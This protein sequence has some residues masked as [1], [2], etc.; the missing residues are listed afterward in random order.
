MQ[1]ATA[2]GNGHEQYGWWT[3][4]IT[5]L[6]VHI[7]EPRLNP[8]YDDPAWLET[9][10]HQN[11]VAVIHT[12]EGVEG[13][14]TNKAGVL[15]QLASHWSN[16]KEY[17]EGQDP[18]NRGQIDH[19]VSTLYRWPIQVR[20]ALD[21]ALW[22]LAGKY[23]QQPIYKLLGATREKV[24]A[25]GSTTHHDSIE[26]FVETSLISKEQGFKAIKIHPWCVAEMDIPI[27]YAVRKAVGDD[28][29]LMLDSLTTYPAQYTRK[30]AMKVGRVLD[31]LDF[32]WFEDPLDKQDQ[33]GLAWL[34]RELKVNIRAA[35]KVEDI[36]EYSTLIANRCMDILAGPGGWGITEL[37]KLSGLA[38]A[39]FLGFEPHDYSGGTASL[40][41]LLATKVG[42]YY[43]KAVPQGKWFESSYP[44]VYLDPVQ[45]DREGYVHGPKK[46][47]LGF[48]VDWNE[49]KKVTA[50]TIR[51]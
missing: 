39:N 38:E 37:V 20:G 29:V 34:T 4:K 43:E 6:T 41:V 11:A 44:G 25:Y 16:A 22:D 31:E 26:K 12:D 2:K 9:P 10:T 30:E 15:R 1:E 46:P 33:E 8:R 19:M 27:C 45:V 48:E 24:L 7:L 13:I 49:V 40:H 28:M 42:K 3:L 5:G 32:W 21:H 23:Y 14:A 36:R 18:F 17:I 47:G 51:S 35:D 50:A